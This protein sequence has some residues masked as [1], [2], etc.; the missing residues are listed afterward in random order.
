MSTSKGGERIITIR[1]A[2]KEALVEEMRR[3]PKVIYVGE[4]VA[5]AGGSFKVTVGL[6]DEFGPDRVIDTPISEAGLCGLCVGAA[7]TGMRPIANISFGDF[8]AL[9]MDQIA[10]QA[11]KMHYMTGGQALVPM[12]FHTTLGAGR[13]SAAQHS[14]SLHAWCAHIPGLKVVLPSTPRDAK[15]LLKSA[16]RDDN[17]VVVYEDKMSYNLTGPVP[18]EEEFLIPLGVAEVKREGQDVTIVATSS[19]VQVALKAAE[20]LE[21]VG[22]SAEVVDPRSLKPLDEDT[23]VSSVKKTHRAVV[24][25]EGYHSYGI[26][27][28]I[29]SVIGDKAFDWLDAPVKRMGAMDVPVPFT[30]VFEFETMPSEGKVVALVKEMMGLP[31]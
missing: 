9:A 31:S 17:P 12:V 22:I 16:I 10:N 23:I 7:M 2:V 15:G 21:E 3:D 19:M 4:D 29:A 8:T 27:A 14:Q 24:I 28:E 18:E 20:M 11:A 5:G 1:E 13:S 30:P 6:L 26:T 25:D